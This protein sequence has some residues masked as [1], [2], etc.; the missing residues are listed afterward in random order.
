MWAEPAPSASSGQELTDAPTP[1]PADGIA[2]RRRALVKRARAEREAGELELGA[3]LLDAAEIDAAEA[4]L[5]LDIIEARWRYRK[6]LVALGAALGQS[7]APNALRMAFGQMHYPR[8][9]LFISVGSTNG[10]RLFDGAVLS[11]TYFMDALDMELWQSLLYRGIETE[12]QISD[13]PSHLQAAY[14]ADQGLVA[15]LTDRSDG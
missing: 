10:K 8:K 12:G 15:A 7:S 9:G 14:D 13:H 5:E 1:V 3:F 6:G 2:R 4:G 11:V